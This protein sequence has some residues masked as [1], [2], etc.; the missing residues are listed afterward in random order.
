MIHGVSRFW[1]T[2][3]GEW[4]MLGSH[5]SAIVQCSTIAD[6]DTSGICSAGELP[7]LTLVARAGANQ[8]SGRSRR[9]AT[10]CPHYPSIHAGYRRMREAKARRSASDQAQQHQQDDG[11]HRRDY[12]GV[13]PPNASD[14]RQMKE[15]PQPRADISADHA[16]DDIADKAKAGF[17]QNSCGQPTGNRADD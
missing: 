4:V 9:G 10:P 7:C 13:D 1:A 14:W 12:D 5:A 11:A 15:V 2:P 6:A 3:S 17:L 8:K 16:D